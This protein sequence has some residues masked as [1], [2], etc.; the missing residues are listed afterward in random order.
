MRLSDLDRLVEPQRIRNYALMLTAGYVL[1]IAWLLVTSSGGLDGAGKPLGADFVAFWTAGQF[2]WEGR[3]AGAYD[4]TVET[5][6]QAPKKL[7]VEVE[8]AATEAVMIQLD[9]R[10]KGGPGR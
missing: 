10:K 4:L 6:S 7:G 3:P 2:V 1:L 9:P 8:G 5:R